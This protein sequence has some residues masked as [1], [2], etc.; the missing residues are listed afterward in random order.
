MEAGRLTLG[1]EVERLRDVDAAFDELGASLLDV[2]D[3]EMQALDT[4]GCR[5]ADAGADRDR[6]RGLRRR[7]L[8]DTERVA[9]AV[10]DVQ[11]KA[12]VLIELLGSVHIGDRQHDQLQLHIHD[13]VSL[14]RVVVDGR[15]NDG[16]PRNS[17]R[18]R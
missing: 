13:V 1:A 9:G 8:H 18:V 15:C 11:P 6:A 2:G 3:D 5:L 7:E 4:P 17:S 14:G 10:I 16:G 12:G